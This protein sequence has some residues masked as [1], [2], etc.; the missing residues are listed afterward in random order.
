MAQ[1]GRHYKE[2]ERTEIYITDKEEITSNDQAVTIKV[3]KA[4]TV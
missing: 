2:V 3:Y 4:P 1:A